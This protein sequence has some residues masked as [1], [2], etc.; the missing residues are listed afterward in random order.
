MQ[1]YTPPSANK[2]GVYLQICSSLYP[3]LILY[4]TVH[5]NET[6]FF[7]WNSHPQRDRFHTIYIY[8]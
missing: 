4:T 8:K 5:R 1:K 6:V 3:Y 2:G 7:L